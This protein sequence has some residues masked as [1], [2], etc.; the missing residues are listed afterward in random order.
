MMEV[1]M[2]NTPHYR[3]QRATDRAQRP[4]DPEHLRVDVIESISKGGR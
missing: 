1:V 2:F 4:A 3:S